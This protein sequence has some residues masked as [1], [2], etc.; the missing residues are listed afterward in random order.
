MRSEEIC[1]FCLVSFFSFESLVNSFWSLQWLLYCC[2]VYTSTLCTALRCWVLLY[3]SDLNV[4]YNFFF[5][6]FSSFPDSFIRWLFVDL[7]LICARLPYL[8]HVVITVLLCI[9]NAEDKMRIQ[10]RAHN[11]YNIVNANNK[12][13]M[14]NSLSCA[15][16]FR[17]KKYIILCLPRFFWC[18]LMCGLLI[19]FVIT[20]NNWL[21]C[22]VEQCIRNNVI[23]K[24]RKLLII[25][26]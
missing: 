7:H 17:L 1:R 3:G 18:R 19:L 8:R 24:M 20:Q 12:L 26:E 10:H 21:L 11:W 23:I 14:C 2:A 15:C 13:C 16:A 25:N 22:S 4:F 6:F 9:S 5:S